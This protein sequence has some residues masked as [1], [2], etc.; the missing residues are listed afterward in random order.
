M[1]TAKLVVLVVFA[2]LCT[3]PANARQWSDATG[4]FKLEAEVFATSSD[5]VV[6]KKKSGA[7]VAF[8]IDQLSPD[9]QKFL[10]AQKAEAKNEV[11]QATDPTT[12]IQ[13]W[14]SRDGF[15]LRGRVIAFGRR[16][17][18]IMRLAGV[19]NVN[20]TA[21]SRLHPFYRYIVP[22]VVA[23]F[24]DSSVKTEQDVERWLKQNNGNAPVFNIE[25][26][27]LKLE[28]GSELAIPFFLFSEKDL[29]VLNPGWEQW[30]AEQASQEDRNRE[31]FLMSVQADSY[32]K[33]REAEAASHQIQMMQLELLAV[34]AGVVSVWEVLLR[35][36]PGVYGREMSVMVTARDSLQAEQLVTR[37]YPGFATVGVRRASN[38]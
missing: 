4:L 24:A 25:G 12:D 11:D 31:S 37:S 2:L 22:K 29:A 33:Q 18:V 36:K 20:G 13:T 16:E 17:V 9:D 10:A 3:R 15:E 6:L 27:L 1:P 32:Q 8:K 21:L 35:P 7:L 23:Q 38:Y 30:K 34:N 19:V 28:D 5:T 14:T 26:V